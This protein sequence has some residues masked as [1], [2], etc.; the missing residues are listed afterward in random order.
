MTAGQQ[1]A[2]TQRGINA[3][4]LAATLT[5][6]GLKAAYEADPTNKAIKAAYLAAAEELRKLRAVPM[7]SL[8]PKRFAE[9]NEGV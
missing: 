6:D 3:R 1:A 5:Y 9:I 2:Q 4:L 8:A 7:P